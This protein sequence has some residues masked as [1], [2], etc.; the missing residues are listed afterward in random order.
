VQASRETPRG[1]LAW[2][3]LVRPDGRLLC[4]GALPTLIQ[5]DGTHPAAQL[6]DSGLALSALTLAGV[7]AAAREMLQLRGVQVQSGPGPAL[8]ATLLTPRGEVILESP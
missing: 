8:S 2:Q 1:R 6:P 3:I 5:W 4:G 7:P